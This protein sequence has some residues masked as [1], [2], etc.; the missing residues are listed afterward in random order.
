MSTYVP[1]TG[2][3]GNPGFMIPHSSAPIADRSGILTVPW[4]AFLRNL[5]WAVPQVGAAPIPTS[6]GATGDVIQT[7]AVTVNNLAVWA[8]D[9]HIKDGGPVSASST[10]SIFLLMGG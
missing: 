7:G 2:A 4:Q 9:H 3:N 8:S 6:G 1:P 5:G 10:P